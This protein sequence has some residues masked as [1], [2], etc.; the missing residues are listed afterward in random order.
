MGIH[1]WGRSSVSEMKRSGVSIK[2]GGAIPSVGMTF[3]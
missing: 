2:T 3:I 1:N